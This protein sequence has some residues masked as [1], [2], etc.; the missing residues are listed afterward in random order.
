MNTDKRALSFYVDELNRQNYT[1]KLLINLCNN[2]K[3]LTALFF[4]QI[5]TIYRL[6]VDLQ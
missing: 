1:A 6:F 5:N 3:M 4:K 2:Y